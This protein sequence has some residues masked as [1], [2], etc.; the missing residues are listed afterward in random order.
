[1]NRYEPYIFCE[2]RNNIDSFPHKNVI[3]SPRFN[4]LEKMLKSGFFQLIH[5][6]FGTSGIKMMPL[7]QKWRVPLV[8][9][10]HGCDSPGTEK[11]KKR[12]KSLQR[13]FSIGDG[14]T[15]P[16]Q[17]MKDE[18]INHGCPEK[19]ITVHYSGIDLTQFAYKERHFPANGPVR[20]VFVGRLVEKKGADQLIKA[21]H[22]VHQV[23]PQTRLTLIGDG[24]L[25]GHLKQLSKKLNLQRQIE[26][27]GALPHN[28]VAKQLEQAHIFCL[29]SMKDRTGN[30]EGIPNAIKEAMACGLPVVSTFHSG[31]PELVE[32]GVTGHLVEERDVDGLAWKLIDVMKNPE[33][34]RQLGKNARN[35]I[36]TSF[37][38]Q[39]QTE[40]LEQLFD[41]VIKSYEDEERERPF[42]S[43]IIPTYNRERYIG[44]AIRSVLQQTSKDYEIIVVDDGST[45]QTAKI[46]NSFGSQVR[47]V[48]QKNQGPSEARN[49]G[50]RLARGTYIALL[51]SDD[52]F[53]PMKL[54]K[55][56]QFLEKNPNCRFL[57]SWYYDDRRRRKKRLV[58][59]L[60]S[61]TNLHQF[62]LNLYKR[63]FTIR[64]STVVIHHSCFFN[65]GFFNKRYHYSQ[66]WDL[67]L[68]LAS[69]YLGYCQ[70]IP[71]AIYRRHQRKRIPGS[72]R[73]LLIRKNASKLYKW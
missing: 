48:Y 65:I 5:A 23:F 35:K 52:Q 34:W 66:D 67:W 56:K 24:E 1:M 11:M 30:Q 25:K 59:N 7:K 69:L 51:D 42:F 29:P 58:R 33:T 20:I 45:D 4:R 46:V 71:L 70:K 31:I 73:H 37:N 19:K 3:V 14:F 63:K 49:T 41:K 26:F 21:F 22:H 54:S 64:T 13:L 2:K 40:K 68:R 36:E 27:M 28:E 15:V 50:I 62:R 43:V 32:D 12:R 38:R 17:A 55:N 8:T 18:L 9:S 44:K 61:F 16:C 53:L 60:K 6:R 57:Y 39:V 47:Y 10:F 72:K